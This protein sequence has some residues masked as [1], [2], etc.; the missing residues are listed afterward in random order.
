MCTNCLPQALDA[1]RDFYDTDD[2]D[3]MMRLAA[4]GETDGEGDAMT[5]SYLSHQHVDEKDITGGCF[6][7][8]DYSVINGVCVTNRYSNFS[9][10]WI[11]LSIGLDSGFWMAITEPTG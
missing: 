6:I 1:I 3:E 7:I 9:T 5:F 10:N 8:D 2:I 4:E 11:D